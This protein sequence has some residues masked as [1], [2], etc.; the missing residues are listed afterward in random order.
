MC[1]G[2]QV[3]RGDSLP[4]SGFSPHFIR[5]VVVVGG[6]VL[7]MGNYLFDFTREEEETEKEAQAGSDDVFTDLFHCV[8][9]FCSNNTCGQGHK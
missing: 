7:L 5:A 9:G 2:A 1:G 3:E 6:V 8:V 4:I